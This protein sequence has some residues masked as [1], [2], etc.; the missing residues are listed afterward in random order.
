MLVVLMVTSLS[1]LLDVLHELFPILVNLL[2]HAHNVLHLDLQV[3]QRFTPNDHFTR[4][5]PHFCRNILLFDTLPLA[6]LPHVRDDLHLQ[7]IRDLP[8]VGEL[9]LI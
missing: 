3:G 1:Q 6:H 4:W 2:E 9:H 5:R 8:V 7:Y